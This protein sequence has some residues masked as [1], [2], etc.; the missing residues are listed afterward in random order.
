[1]CVCV[2]RDR[3]LTVSFKCLDPAI[4]EASS[5]WSSFIWVMPSLFTKAVCGGFLSLKIESWEHNIG[6]NKQNLHRWGNPGKKGL[7][8]RQ[9]GKKNRGQGAKLHFGNCRRLSVAGAEM[10]RVDRWTRVTPVKALVP[11]LTFVYLAC[12][13]SECAT[14]GLQSCC[15]M[16]NLFSCGMW[17]L[18]Y[19]TWD[20]VPW[21]GLNPGPLHWKRV[22]LA[23]GPWEKSTIWPCMR[24]TWSRPG[25]LS[26]GMMWSGLSFR[27]SLRKQI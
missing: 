27:R 4:P 12:I 10:R 15:C 18:G 25:V 19:V 9:E 26:S 13:R 3:Q 5:N 6:K 22:V 2:H 8:R 20:L 14:L 23:T 17:T 1:M 7:T 11:C 21:L 16:W 24:S